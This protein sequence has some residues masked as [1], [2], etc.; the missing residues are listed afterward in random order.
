MSEF[1][2]LIC[3]SYDAKEGGGFQPAGASLHNV[4][5][6]HGA[7]A[8]THEKASNMELRS[9]K[10]GTGSIA[11][12]FESCMMLGLTDWGLEEC[13]KVQKTYNQD[14][15]VPLKRFFT[16]PK[17]GRADLSLLNN[18]NGTGNCIH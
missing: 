1:M 16:G 8:S 9:I 13:R 15:W 11:F 7:D 4:M 5:A 18:G 17:H 12:M 2:G 3:G 10:V 14:S 6:A